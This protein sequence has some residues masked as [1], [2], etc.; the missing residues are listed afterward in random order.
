MDVGEVGASGGSRGP[1]PE[2]RHQ[3]LGGTVQR[4]ADNHMR[5]VPICTNQKLFWHRFIDP[6]VHGHVP[7]NESRRFRRRSR[8]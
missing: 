1:D 7:K 8:M 5:V 3:P 6:G 2:M 4:D